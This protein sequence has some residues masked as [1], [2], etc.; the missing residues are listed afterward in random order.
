MQHEPVEVNLF[1][2]NWPNI[3]PKVRK[4]ILDQ[5]IRYVNLSRKTVNAGGAY[6]ANLRSLVVM[7]IASLAMAIFGIENR[8]IVLTLM[9]IQF[10]KTL[11]A[12]LF[13]V[14]LHDATD[15][16][17]KDFK[18]FVTDKMKSVNLTI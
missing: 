1:E 16:A 15:I 13:E 14:T 4:E 9:G 3:S 6:T 8:T 2:I 7:L 5:H 17:Q 12:R 11:A 10:S 18:S